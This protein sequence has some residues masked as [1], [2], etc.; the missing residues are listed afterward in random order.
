MNDVPYILSLAYKKQI[1]DVCKPLASIGLKHFVMYVIFNDGTPFILSNVYPVTQAYYRD[2]LYKEDYNYTPQMI[3]HAGEGYLLTNKGE[4]ISPR[5][6][7]MLAEEYKIYPVYNLVRRCAECTFVFSAI[8]GV[9]TEDSQSFY[10]KT[11]RSFENFCTSFVDAFLE[12]IEFCN[13]KYKYS[14]ILTNKHFRHAII[15]RGY[16]DQSSISMR[17]RECLWL[18]AQGN[19]GKQIAQMLK[20]S[21]YTVEKY[22]KNIR[23]TFN[24]STLVEAVVEGI[25]RGLIG[26]MNLNTLSP[27]SNST[28][29]HFARP[30]V[31]KTAA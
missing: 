20:I 18:A 10:D 9:P 30:I 24:C 13:P 15:K 11:V 8:R 27:T 29:P 6:R 2:E 16:S 17:E 28:H 31:Q 25:H 14:F 21:P 5:L 3:E 26:K 12:L 7:A 4:C 1:D 22:L 23:E 19:T